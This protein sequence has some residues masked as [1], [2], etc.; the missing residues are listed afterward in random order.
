MMLMTAPSMIVVPTG[1]GTVTPANDF[2][3]AT[4]ALARMFPFR[5]TAVYYFPPVAGQRLRSG[6]ATVGDVTSGAGWRITRLAPRRVMRQWSDD[7]TSHHSE[8]SSCPAD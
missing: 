8:G 3:G 6:R 7:R 2:P 5:L 1:S 4:S